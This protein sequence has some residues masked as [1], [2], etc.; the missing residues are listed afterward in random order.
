MAIK[1]RAFN[2]TATLLTRGLADKKIAKSRGTFDYSF[3]PLLEDDRSKVL[4]K[5]THLFVPWV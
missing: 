1:L 3:Q 5:C 4:A 2:Y